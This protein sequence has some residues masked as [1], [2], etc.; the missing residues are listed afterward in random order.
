[1]IVATFQA[2]L[3]INQ[4]CSMYMP[5]SPAALLNITMAGLLAPLGKCQGKSDFLQV[6]NFGEFFIR[7]R[8]FLIPIQSD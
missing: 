8:N 3:V 6:R 2:Y 4:N 5:V 7:T 1:M